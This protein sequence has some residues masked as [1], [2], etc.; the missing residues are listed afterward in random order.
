M[1]RAILAVGWALRGRDRLAIDDPAI[2]AEALFGLWQGAS[3]F[4]LSLG[5]DTDDTAE[6]VAK[7]VDYGIAV[8]VRAF[9]SPAS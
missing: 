1:G 5:I 3:N 6:A 2:A 8:F 9:S 4:Q 7:R